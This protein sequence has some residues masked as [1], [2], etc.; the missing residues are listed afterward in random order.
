[1]Y[2]PIIAIDNKINEPCAFKLKK[3]WDHLWTG[4][5]VTLFE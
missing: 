1:M 2:L 4:N 5:Y 3:N